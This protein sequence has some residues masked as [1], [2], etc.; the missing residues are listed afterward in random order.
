MI[1]VY[2]C[3]AS[4][5]GHAAASRRRWRMIDGEETLTELSGLSIETFARASKQERH[6]WISCYV[7]YVTSETGRLVA[8]IPGSVAD[9]RDEMSLLAETGSLVYVRL[10]HDLLR[11]YAVSDPRQQ[12]SS[13]EVRQWL[14]Q[15]VDRRDAALVDIAHHVVDVTGLG[16]AEVLS[17]ARLQ[18]VGRG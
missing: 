8:S 9:H 11:D 17:L 3:L 16:R 4:T 13:D 5:V 1:G 7:R 6:D 2:G 12:R 10:P 15:I 14:N 18:L